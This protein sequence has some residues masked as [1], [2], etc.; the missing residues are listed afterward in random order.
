MANTKREK[1]G[2]KRSK[3][4]GDQDE[5]MH[6]VYDEEGG[7]VDQDGAPLEFSRCA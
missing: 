5:Y 7:E 4:V 6:D 1:L 2:E 3:C